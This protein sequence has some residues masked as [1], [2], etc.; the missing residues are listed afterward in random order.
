MTAAGLDGTREGIYN[1][2]PN[3]FKV[4]LMSAYFQDEISAS[5]KFKVSP[6][7]RFDYSYVGNQPVIDAGLNATN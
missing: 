6:G 2:P 1:N 4:A 3:P 5:S 7:I